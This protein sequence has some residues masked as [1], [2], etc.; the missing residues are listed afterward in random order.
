MGDPTFTGWTATLLYGVACWLCAIKRR[1]AGRSAHYDRQVWAMLALLMA[2]LGINK[3]LDLQTWVIN[4]ARTL[5]YRLSLDEFRKPIGLFVLAA[6]AL[7]LF[8]IVVV[9]IYYFR[10]IRSDARLA[11]LGSGIVL[12]YAFLRAAQFTH[13]R[14]GL[15]IHDTWDIV[16]ELLGLVIIVWAARPSNVPVHISRHQ[17][18][19]KVLREK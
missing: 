6:A 13:I 3:Q 16:V 4:L 5:L 15:G 8:G 19:V 1:K 9:G 10:R 18:Q 12:I 2:V 7:V 11:L 17:V 14:R